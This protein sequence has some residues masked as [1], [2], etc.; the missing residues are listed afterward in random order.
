MCELSQIWSAPVEEIGICSDWHDCELSQTNRCW[1]NLF[2]WPR[3]SSLCNRSQSISL[4]SCK[5]SG[6]QVVISYWSSRFYLLQLKHVSPGNSFFFLQIS[7]SIFTTGEK[8]QGMSSR[9][10]ESIV[11]DL[12]CSYKQPLYGARYSILLCVLC[13]VHVTVVC[14]AATDVGSPHEVSSTN[15]GMH[16]FWPDEQKMTLVVFK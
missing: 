2:Y 16:T 6:P 9:D 3:S 10:D 4:K 11:N 13:I 1:L 15:T 8:K 5:T 12:H 7:W 14:M